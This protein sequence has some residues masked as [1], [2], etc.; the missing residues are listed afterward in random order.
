MKYGCVR[1]REGPADTW[2]RQAANPNPAASVA[3]EWGMARL[4]RGGGR[5]LGLDR[6][7]CLGV[8]REGGVGGGKVPT[9]CTQKAVIDANHLLGGLLHLSL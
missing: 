8:G 7:V 4:G 5:T 2:A 6:T 3:P 9:L 1:G